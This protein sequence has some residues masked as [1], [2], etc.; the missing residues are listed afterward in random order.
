MERVC[1]SVREQTRAIRNLKNHCAETLLQTLT[2]TVWGELLCHRIETVCSG[3]QVYL[4]Y[5]V[6][7]QPTRW[8][9]PSL[10]SPAYAN[11]DAHILETLPPNSAIAAYV[12]EPIFSENIAVTVVK[13][14]RD[15]EASPLHLVSCWSHPIKSNDGTV[16]GTLAFYFPPNTK[17]LVFLKQIVDACRPYCLLAIERESY[18][19]QLRKLTDFDAL[20]NVF[21]RSHMDRLI[22][23]SL[24]TDIGR[25]MSL[26]I[27]DIDRL[28]DVNNA[29]GHDAGDCVLIEIATRLQKQ[30]NGNQHLG[31]FGSDQ[32]LIVALDHTIETSMQDAERILETLNKPM[33]INGYQLYVSASIGISHCTRHELKSRSE[34]LSRA[35]AALQCGKEKGGNTY[36]VF[37]PAMNVLSQERLAKVSELKFAIIENRL[38]LQYQPQVYSGSGELYGVEAL[39]RWH[40]TQ[41]GEVPAGSFISLAEETGQIDALGIWVIREA[42]RQMSEW[43]K[44][45]LNIPVIS[46]N[47]SP[48]NFQNTELPAL[49]ANVLREFNIAGRSLTIEITESTMLKLTPAMLCIVHEIR[50]LGIGLSVD[51][52]GTGYASLSNLINLPLSEIKIDRSFVDASSH[53]TRQRT[54]IETVIGIGR[55]LGL[56]VIAEGVETSTQYSL[57]T[58]Y[59]CPIQ[60]GYYFAKPLDPDNMST[61]LSS[62]QKMWS[63]KSD[64]TLN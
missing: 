39:A 9:A 53:H 37:S 36:H 32:F 44:E 16:K 47:L 14:P 41:F 33:N 61:W 42:C 26:S 50:D 45:G 1:S 35:K 60:Q 18:I 62:H 55:K 29:M 23:T 58:N 13:L 5:L 19:T 46:V 25:G 15:T 11:H 4:S 40:S 52:F 22:N 31:R 54:L 30:L 57:L 43:R 49:L 28:K 64:P 56:K 7:Q 48:I 20:T 8:A 59:E 24:R 6:D 51:D 27:L 2:F 34:L 3:V 63:E 12:G 10:P 21:N 17:S 38:R